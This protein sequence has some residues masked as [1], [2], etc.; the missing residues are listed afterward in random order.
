MSR[1]AF[2]VRR[3]VGS[4]NRGLRS[5]GRSSSCFSVPPR[6][7]SREDR[8]QCRSISSLRLTWAPGLDIEGCPVLNL[9]S[10]TAL[11]SAMA[12]G[13][14]LIMSATLV[15]EC[16][17]RACDARRSA[18]MASMPSQKTHFL[19]VEQRWLRAAASV[20]P[21]T[22]LNSNTLAEPKVANVRQRMASEGD[23]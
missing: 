10:D 13:R 21:K 17:R 23:R 20:A 11:P 19:E 12:S 22:A 1:F 9:S 8:S 6:R 15:E 4:S 2:A 7:H 16:Y 18:E 5:L 14:G 3:H